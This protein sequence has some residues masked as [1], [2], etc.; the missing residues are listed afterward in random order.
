MQGTISPDA[1]ILRKSLHPLVG[2]AE[3]YDPLL[4]IVDDA[5][6]VLLGE[7]S[8]G[9]HEF[10]QERAEITKRLITEKGFRAGEVEA[11][12]PDAYRINRFV[13]GVGNDTESIAALADFTRFPTWMRRN[14]EAVEFIGCLRAYNA[15]V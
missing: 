8:H 10:Y 15:A 6:F 2:S 7:A 4:E 5:R 1:D 12:W 13:R 11:D 14:A 3:D 9:S